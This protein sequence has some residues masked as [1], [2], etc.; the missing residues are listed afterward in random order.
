MRLRL[1]ATWSL[2][3]RLAA[4]ILVLVVATVLVGG[5]GL[6]AVRE[7]Q[8]A[9]AAS[10]QV[11]RD[12]KDTLNSARAA[13]LA[14]RA[15]THEFRHLLLRGHEPADYSRYLGSFHERSQE[16]DRALNAVKPALERAGLPADGVDDAQRLHASVTGI[17]LEALKLFEPDKVDTIRAVDVLVRGKDR[18]LND[19]IDAIVHALQIYA[20][21]EAERLVEA[22]VAQSRRAFAVLA[23]AVVLLVLLAAT[24]GL[25]IV[26]ALRKELGGE[27]AYAKEVASRIAA[28][29][30]AT[31]VRTVARDEGSLLAAMKRMQEDLRSVVADVLRGARTVS[32]TSAGIARANEELSHRTEQQASTLEETASAM[33]E[34]ASTVSQNADNA[35]NAAL[36]A[37]GAAEVAARGGSVVQ[38]VVSTMEGISDSSRRISDII[39]VIDGIAFQT[40]ILALNAAVEA[41]RAGDQGRGFAVVAAEVRNLA[42]R[43][44]AAA[45]EIK[46]LIV[47]SVGKVSAGSAQ[48]SSA[49]RTMAEIVSSF[50]QVRELIAGIAAASEEQRTGLEQVSAAVTQMERVVQQNASMV[51]EASLATTAMKDQAAALVQTMARFHLDDASSGLDE[52]ANAPRIRPAEMVLIPQP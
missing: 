36:L 30:L 12:L 3:A 49:G 24:L 47:D 8:S 44:A 11:Q 42:Q 6:V 50:G 7:A 4:P 28:G 2:A 43:S 21:S 40:N 41:A 32:G 22:S 38:Q 29:D 5:Y 17:Y 1:F 39:G 16:F 15:Q 33:E 31:R 46:Q 37:A 9:N 13:G 48:V 20:D 51:E 26:R 34:L 27:P 14:F 45:R 19:K 23:G 52:A 10:L 35:R 25:L 18:Q